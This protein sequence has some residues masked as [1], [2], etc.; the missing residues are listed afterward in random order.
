MTTANTVPVGEHLTWKPW[1]TADDIPLREHL[2]IQG[3]YEDYHIGVFDEAANGRLYCVVNGM[4]WFDR[5]IIR[6]ALIE[7]LL[8]EKP[9]ERPEKIQRKPDYDDQQ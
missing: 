4:A 9:P 1:T 2:L 7:H 5:T 6:W 8:A 3:E